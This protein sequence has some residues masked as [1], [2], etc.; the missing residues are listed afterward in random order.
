MCTSPA[1]EGKTKLK[2]LQ[3][4][5]KNIHPKKT[6]LPRGASNCVVKENRLGDGFAKRMQDD[7]NRKRILVA[8]GQAGLPTASNMNALVSY[9]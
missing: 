4:L 6:E 3:R 8:S 2:Y 5:A 7:H 9:I 1:C